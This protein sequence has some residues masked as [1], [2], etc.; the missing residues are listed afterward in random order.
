MDDAA[1]HGNC[2]PD[3]DLRQ[4]LRPISRILRTTFLIHAVAYTMVQIVLVFL[5]ALGWQRSGIAHPW[6]IYPMAGWGIG[7]AAHYLAVSPGWRPT[8]NRRTRV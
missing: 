5:W 4:C 8:L 7:L 1:P 3:A 6:F 2:Q